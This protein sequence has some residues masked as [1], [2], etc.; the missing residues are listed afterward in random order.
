MTP[1]RHAQAISIKG[2]EQMSNSHPKLQ[3]AGCLL[4]THCRHSS[5]LGVLQ[6]FPQREADGTAPIVGDA[7]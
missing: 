5:G 2:G 3:L 6:S 4:S 7:N 1:R